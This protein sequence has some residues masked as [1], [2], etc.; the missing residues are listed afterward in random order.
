VETIKDLLVWRLR[1]VSNST[2]HDARGRSAMAKRECHS[3]G[4]P[5]TK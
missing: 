3:F 5:P 4:L 1:A 2:I